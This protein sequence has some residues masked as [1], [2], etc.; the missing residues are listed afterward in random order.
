MFVQSSSIASKKCNLN[1]SDQNMQVSQHE[2]NSNVCAQVVTQEQSQTY[3]VAT[4]DRW[5]TPIHSE[6]A[7]KAS[8]VHKEHNPFNSTVGQQHQSSPPLLPMQKLC[9]LLG[10]RLHKEKD[11]FCEEA[12]MFQ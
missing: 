10:K 7:L 9:N 5:S 4:E 3:M 1:D 11:A 12:L 8:K 2:Q 6:T